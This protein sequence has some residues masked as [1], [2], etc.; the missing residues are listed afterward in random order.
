LSEQI[1]IGGWA[2]HLIQRGAPSMERLFNFD[3]LITPSII[4]FLFYLGVVGSVLGA[5]VIIVSG[6]GIMRWNA[7]VGIGYIL[8]GLLLVLVGIVASR[9][10]T[11]IILV[12]FMIRD[13]LAWQRQQRQ[14]GPAE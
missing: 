13:E 9:V 3:S 12:V 2:Q 6:L 10:A 5:L 8:G 1:T 11:E 4:K 7:L 14:G